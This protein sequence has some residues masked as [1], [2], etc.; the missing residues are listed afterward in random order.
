MSILDHFYLEEERLELKCLLSVIYYLE[1]FVWS[2]SVS[3]S[4]WPIFLAKSFELAQVRNE[5]GFND[6]SFSQKEAS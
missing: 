1:K 2:S 3:W 5:G 6:L 4:N